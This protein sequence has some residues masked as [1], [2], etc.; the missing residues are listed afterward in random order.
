MGVQ[1]FPTLKIVRPNKKGGK[2]SVEDYQGP[3]T[4]TGIVEAV[5]EKINNHVKRITD[6]DI[7]SFLSEKNETAKAILFTEKGTTS[8]LLR[9]LAIDFLDAITVGQV[10]SKDKKAVDMFGVESF[11]ALILLPGGTKD[12]LVYEGE[13]KKP[14]MLDF[15]SQ[16]ATP[17]PDAGRTVE[18]EKKPEKKSEKK[19]EPKKAKASPAKASKSPKSAEPA[20][21]SAT[22]AEGDSSTEPPSEQQ[23]MPVVLKDTALPIPTILSAE[24]LVKECLSERSGTCLLALVPTEKHETADK[25][26]DAL[27]ELAAKYAKADH[28]LFPFFTIP[29]V[30]VGH[31]HLVKSFELTG[32]VEV[33]AVNAKRSWWRHY[34]GD[35]SADSLEKWIDAIRMSEGAKSKLP[36]GVVAFAEE[37][38]AGEPEPTSGTDPTPEPETAAQEKPTASEKHDEL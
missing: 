37:T 26:L 20:K 38:P 9:S 15:L 2:A 27:A 12:A 23:T 24:K 19:T 21:E 28:K 3:R 35:S 5:V 18:P 17:N 16:A 10:R 6:K 4:A 1:G 32:E 25:L 8:A 7:D 33:V 13:M 11:P 31:A 14:A 22:E 29:A 30:N 34:E 36:E